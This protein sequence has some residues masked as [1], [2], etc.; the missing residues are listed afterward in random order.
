M[1]ANSFEKPWSNSNGNPCVMI[2]L[3]LLFLAAITTLRM[4]P[5]KQTL[6]TCIK[7]AP[8]AFFTVCCPVCLGRWRLTP[9]IA[10]AK[11]WCRDWGQFWWHLLRFSK[12]L[13]CEFAAGFFAVL[14][15][16]PFGRCDLLLR[17]FLACQ[18][19]QMSCWL[20]RSVSWTGPLWLVVL[21]WLRRRLLLMQRSLW[22]RDHPSGDSIWAAV[23]VWQVV[24]CAKL[25]ARVHQ[26]AVTC[27]VLAEI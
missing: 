7:W 22:S 17:V 19:R 4:L 13:L 18:I 11:L 14:A 5:W 8:T 25:G 6:D 15:S 9:G 23:G 12:P 21:L 2:S 26:P 24:V 3:W 16:F 27:Q 10:K 20:Y 1:P